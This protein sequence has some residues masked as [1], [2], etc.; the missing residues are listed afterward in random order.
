[1][2]MSDHARQS[3]GWQLEQ[4]APQAY[5]EYLVP[6]MFAP[7]ADRL[8]ETGKVQEGDRVLDVACGTGIVARHAVSRVRERGSV[9][10]VDINAEML[11]VAE[12]TAAGLQPPVEWRQGDATNLPFADE[13]FDV[14]CCQ[15][16]IQFFDNPVTAIREIR[17]VLVPGGRVAVSVW[18]PI[19]YQ[20]VYVAFADALEDRISDEAGAMMRSPFPAWDR[21]TLRTFVRDAGFEDASVTIEIGTI[22]YPSVEE[23]VRREAASSPFAAQITAV[24][25]DVQEELVRAVAQACRGYVDDAGLISPME[26]HVVAADR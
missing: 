11:A 19:A 20:P 21:E 6:P 4:S 7:W 5:E 14:V 15:Q 9:V 22:R 24:D 18:R 26:S 10:G 23:F 1:M 3:S 8:L 17:R 12:E 25:R 13:T 16:A 2:R